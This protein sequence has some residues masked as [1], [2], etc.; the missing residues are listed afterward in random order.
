MWQIKGRDAEGKP[1]DLA[2]TEFQSGSREEIHKSFVDITGGTSSEIF[3]REMAHQDPL[4]GVDGIESWGN[5]AADLTGPDGLL[6]DAQLAK[7][8]SQDVPG[9]LLQQAG[10]T[11]AFA[12]HAPEVLVADVTGA[13]QLEI[14]AGH[15][16]TGPAGP[17]FTMSG[18]LLEARIYS[19]GAVIETDTESETAAP[20]F[21]VGLSGKPGGLI[22]RFA[23]WISRP[24]D[25]SR[26]PFMHGRLK[27]YEER[28]S[29]IAKH[30]PDISLAATNAGLFRAIHKAPAGT[31]V[32][33]FVHGTYSCAVP[34]LALLHP[35]KLP[36]YRF[37][38][39]TFLPVTENKARL[40]KA[41]SD[42]IP[43]GARVHLVAHSRGGLVSRL[44]ARELLKHY[45][46]RL[47]TYGTPHKG[48]PLA[49]AGKRIFS[50]LLAGG[51]TALLASG[52][53]ALGS[54]FSWDP[55]SLGGKLLLKG[56]LPKG[57]P[58]GLD[59]MRPE[60][61]FIGS[62]SAV[63]EPYPL[64]TW[65]AKCEV[66]GL[67]SGT[68]AFAIRDAIYGAFGGSANDTVVGAASATGAGKA[69]KIFDAC[70]HFQYFSVP[71]VK[72]E[73]QSLS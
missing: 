66:D 8:E 24:F 48:T 7:T 16:T 71:E 10:Q 20:S 41:V 29:V 39:D 68:F 26:D 67:P 54:V 28:Y 6:Y 47:M 33:V 64:R 44:A 42:F 63:T 55:P 38:H 32:I 72:A 70:T 30:Y 23:S 59:A 14:S 35:L 18:A 40:V 49:N 22:A 62:L 21:R 51:R 2:F 53:A 60:S 31:A 12:F 13:R 19:E 61:D 52:G 17:P 36:A 34:H 58:P 69:Q 46:V 65:G 56:I 43:A 45:D 4:P 27:H 5:R 15:P 37:E 3:D 50:A 1:R 25:A 73:I 57:F 9:L 11:M